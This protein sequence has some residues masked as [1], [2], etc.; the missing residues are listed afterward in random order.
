MQKI[1]YENSYKKDFTAEIVDI[2][3]IDEKF[4]V[5]LDKTAFYPEGGGQLCDIGKIESHD[6][7]YVYEKEGVIYH[8]LDQAPKKI[9]K[10]K[11]SLNWNRREY[12]MSHHL[13]QHIISALFLKEFNKKTTSFHMGIEISTV[14][15]EGSFSDD[16]IMKIEQLANDVISEN[17]LVETFEITRKE[18]KK[19]RLK[20]DFSK[21]NGDIRVVKVGDLDTNCCCGVHPKSTLDLRLIKFKKWEKYKNSTRI[22]YFAG[23]KAIDYVINRDKNL[24]KICKYLSCSDEDSL[25]GIENINNKLTDSINENKKLKEEIAQYELK[26]MI[27]SG[28]IIKDIFIITKIYNDKDSKYISK[29]ANK[30]TEKDNKVVLFALV[31]KDR[32][33][34]VFSCSKNL[35]ILDMNNL[36]KDSIKLIDGKGGGSKITAQGGG[37][38]NSNLESLMSYTAMKVEKELS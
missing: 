2:K 33:N 36:L 4:H 16:E 32:V 34:L 7:D 17:I 23:N 20:D 3:K 11:C 35:T 24:S 29:L 13:S 9:H 19:L 14:D 27:S 37:K 30:I 18:A 1:F 38:N 21:I 10:V 26:D 6:V 15:I 28:K 5:V 8:V 31:N 12:T 22:E 25:K